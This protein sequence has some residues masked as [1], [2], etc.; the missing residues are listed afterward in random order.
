M[1]W[2][3]NKERI[4]Q[5]EELV[6]LYSEK[7]EEK[8]T[9]PVYTLIRAPGTDDYTAFHTRISSLIE[10]PIFLFYLHQMRLKYTDQFEVS[11]KDMAEFYRGKLAAIGDLFLDARQSKNALNVPIQERSD[12]TV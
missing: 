9:V 5:L 1:V 6:K 12:V 4:K 7:L 11:G 10:D 3:K 2:N 8:K